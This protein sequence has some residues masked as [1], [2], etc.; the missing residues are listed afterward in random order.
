MYKQG[1]IWLVNFDPS[2]VNLVG[3]EK[4]NND[5]KVNIFAFVTIY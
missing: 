1:Q 4:T 3:I 5:W 2:V